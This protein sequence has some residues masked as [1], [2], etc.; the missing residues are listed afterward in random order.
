LLIFYRNQH[1]FQ[2]DYEWRNHDLFIFRNNTFLSLE[3]KVLP[4][5]IP[6]KQVIY[7]CFLYFHVNWLAKILNIKK[8]RTAFTWIVPHSKQISL[9]SNLYLGWEAL[10]FRTSLLNLKPISQLYPVLFRFGGLVRNL[11]GF[12]LN[13]G[14][15]IN[16]FF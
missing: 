6:I 9:L 4:T 16:L 10:M 15:V 11:K 7:N 14:S 12:F 5:I 13:T 8:R 1:G 2:G 3:R